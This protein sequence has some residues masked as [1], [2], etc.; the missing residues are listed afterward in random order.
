MA[1][2][3][4]QLRQQFDRYTTTQKKQFID[5]LKTK[6]VGTNNAEYISF[7]NECTQKYNVAVG[8]GAVAPAKKKKSKKM[9]FLGIGSL[10]LGLVLVGF[11][12]T[13]PFA[14]FLGGLLL[15]TAIIIG[16][17]SLIKFI[18]QKPDASEY[19]ADTPLNCPNCKN[20]VFPTS[21]ACMFCGMLNKGYKG[22][23]SKSLVFAILGLSIFLL[24]EPLVIW[25]IRNF[26]I[27][28]G[29]SM[30]LAAANRGWWDTARSSL[31]QHYMA[32]NI[33]ATI[34]RLIPFVLSLLALGFARKRQFSHKTNAARIMA[35]I[36]MAVN[37]LVL[38][39]SIGV[40]VYQ[41]HNYWP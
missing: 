22:I 27:D 15:W 23:D 40:T 36:G 32:G 38:L 8:G 11:A 34:L 17:V 4:P 2:Q 3:I 41:Y 10:V 19:T 33:F 16:I 25:N 12:E 39:I 37:A 26:F 20:K 9:L 24:L 28:E 21:K 5:N 18:K 13:V 35:I 30:A 31:R 29:Y 7:L 1:S 6:I 14:S